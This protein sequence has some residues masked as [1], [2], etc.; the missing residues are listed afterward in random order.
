M[1]TKYLGTGLDLG[2]AKITN[3]GSPSTAT[4]LV[5]KSY[6]DNVAAGLSAKPSARAAST[7]NLTPAARRR[8]TLSPSL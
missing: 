3:S 2:G 6:V 1:S 7:G 5:P 4:D 8:L